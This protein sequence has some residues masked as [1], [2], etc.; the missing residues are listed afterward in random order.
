MHQAL[1]T[2]ETHPGRAHTA[3]NVKRKGNVN[4]D[5][6]HHGTVHSDAVCQGAMRPDAAHHGI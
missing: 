3:P 4:L 1:G 2:L 5:A 6:A